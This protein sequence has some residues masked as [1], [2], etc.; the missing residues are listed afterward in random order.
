MVVDASQN[1]LEPHPQVLVK[2]LIL[3][4]CSSFRVLRED[5]GY[6]FLGHVLSLG[7]ML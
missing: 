5:G 3:G 4:G 1:Y 6:D 2:L 7:F